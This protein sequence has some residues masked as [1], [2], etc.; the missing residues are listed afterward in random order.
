MESPEAHLHLMTVSKARREGIRRMR[1]QAGGR[2]PLL[3]GCPE[4]VDVSVYPSSGTLK[5]IHLDGFLS[6]LHTV[7]VQIHIRY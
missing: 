7:L 5:W 3:R 6:G 1:S 2:L 4:V